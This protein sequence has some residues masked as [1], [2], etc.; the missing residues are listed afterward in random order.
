MYSLVGGLVPES[1]GGSGWLILLFFLG[2]EGP[3]SKQIPCERS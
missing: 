3:I 2:A 1:S